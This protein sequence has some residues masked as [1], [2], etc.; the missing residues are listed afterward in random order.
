MLVADFAARAG[1]PVVRLAHKIED[2]DPAFERPAVLVLEVP[3]PD[4]S[5]NYALKRIPR[6]TTDKVA[7]LPEEELTTLLRSMLD[8]QTSSSSSFRSSSVRQPAFTCQRH[9][10]RET[11]QQPSTI[12]SDD[13]DSAP[14]G[15]T[16]IV[17]DEAGTIGETVRSAAP[18]IDYWTITDTGSTDGTQDVIRGNLSTSTPGRLVERSFVDFA[19]TRNDALKAHGARTAYTFMPDADFE[20]E[21]MWRLRTIAWRLEQECRFWSAHICGKSMRVVR[22]TTGMA[23]QMQVVFPT[24]EHA[25]GELDGWHYSYPVHEVSALGQDHTGEYIVVPGETFK[26]RFMDGKV[27]HTKSEQRWRDFDI[28][29]LE[30]EKLKSPDDVRVAFYLARTYNQVGDNELALAEF[31]RRIDMGGWY[32]EV[33]HSLLDQGRILSRMGRDPTSKLKEAHELIPN[34]AEPLYELAA[35]EQRQVDACDG[36]ED[37]EDHD[38]EKQQQKLKG[39]WLEACRFQHRALGYTYAKHAAALPYPSHSTLFVSSPVYDVDAALQ[40]VVHGYFLAE[41]SADVFRQGKVAND[42]LASRFPGLEPHASNVEWYGKLS[43]KIE[44]EFEGKD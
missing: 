17:K 16:M 4:D 9:N 42:A 3:P 23:L 15:L 36:G 27:F 11:L 2:V 18:H 40:L 1:V 8:I 13:A 44:E 26:M 28:R 32:E 19:T 38:E 12:L 5:H 14:L 41:L 30:A 7:E 6:L 21:N 29:I 25:L 39:L 31:Q 24:S 37:A 33:F 22:Q 43:Q 35:W 10:F 20:F 34:R